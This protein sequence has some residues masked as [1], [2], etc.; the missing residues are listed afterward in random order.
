MAG[1]RVI[2]TGFRPEPWQLAFA[3]RPAKVKLALCGLGS[4]KSAIGANLA[5]ALMTDPNACRAHGIPWPNFGWV[6]GKDFPTVLNTCW[7]ELKKFLP[8]GVYQANEQL[9]RI[10][11]GRSECQFVACDDPDSLRAGNVNWIWFDEPGIVHSDE[12]WHNVIGRARRGVPCVVFLTGTPKGY[13]WLHDLV[14]A[15]SARADLLKGNE[16]PVV[17]K[18][19]YERIRDTD[20][21]QPGYG[22]YWSIRVPS[23]MSGRVGQDD[24]NRAREEHSP[25]WFMQEYGADFRSFTGLVYQEFD[26]ERDVREDLPEC[27]EWYG[28]LD[29]GYR[30]PAAGLVIGRGDGHVA[31]ADEFYRTRVEPDEQI[32][33]ALE[34]QERYTTVAW[35]ADYHRADLIARARQA[36]LRIWAA[37]TSPGVLAPGLEEVRRHFRSGSVVIHPRCRQTIRELQTYRYP[38]GGRRGAGELP[39][40][41]DNHLMD[42]LRQ[43]LWMLRGSRPPQPAEP[44]RSE[45]PWW[46]RS[47]EPEPE[48][49]YWSWR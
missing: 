46:F 39:V 23:W 48:E 40:D 29:W 32:A 8:P 11:I 5:A 7:R 47:R 2:D 22:D 26:R 42:C 12:V 14:W 34:Q 44:R 4:G 6:V 38:D 37:D 41:A 15:R 10:E 20:R 45:T 13:T 25:D 43:V 35:I 3:R 17:R 9:H 19:R 31:V 28:G 36:G 27:V 24:I 16:Q 21:A 1:P 33:W 18:L 49:A 30:D